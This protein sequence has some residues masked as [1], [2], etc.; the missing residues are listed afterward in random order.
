[1]YIYFN[2]KTI[3][4]QSVLAAFVVLTLHFSGMAQSTSEAPSTTQFSLEI[5]P[6]TFVFKGYGV[7]LRIQPK[8]SK[9]V[10]VGVG[11]YAM[12]FPDLFVGFNEKNKD[13]GW[14]VR[15]NQ[16]LGLFGEYHFCEVNRK[17]FVGGQSSWQQYDLEHAEAEGKSQ[18]SNILFM[19]YGGYTWKPF[20]DSFYFKPWAGLGGTFQVEGENTLGDQEYDIAPI[21]LF[22]TLHIGYTF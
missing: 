5:D 8:N 12:N 18:F 14:E 16:G 22:S 3:S 13:K 15:L 9:H 11:A 19:A 6:A 21:A 2:M 4:L 20:G 17:W 7:H 1:M 10:L